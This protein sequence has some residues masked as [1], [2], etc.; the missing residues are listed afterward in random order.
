MNVNVTDFYFFVMCTLTTFG[1]D[2]RKCH[3]WLFMMLACMKMKE[4]SVM[5][6]NKSSGV[7]TDEGI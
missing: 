5:M 6:T 4:V 2:D 3:E 1:H 7:E